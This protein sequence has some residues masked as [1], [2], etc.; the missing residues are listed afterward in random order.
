MRRGPEGEFEPNRFFD[1]E[2]ARKTSENIPSPEVAERAARIAFALSDETRV[3]V[4]DALMV[5]EEQGRSLNVNNLAAELGVK[6]STLSH[7]LKILRELGVVEREKVGKEA[8]YS[9]DGPN[10]EVVKKFYERTLEQL[11]K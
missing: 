3:R 9:L 1:P 2:A 11:K 8:F 4:F 5:N 7:Q 10:A 6:A